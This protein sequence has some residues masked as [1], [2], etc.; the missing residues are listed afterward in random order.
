MHSFYQLIKKCQA[1][2]AAYLAKMT[3][4]RSLFTEL[5]PDKRKAV[6]GAAVEKA[7]CKKALCCKD[8]NK[9]DQSCVEV[10]DEMEV[11][12]SSC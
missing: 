7:E 9:K 1:S 8:G 6:N 12:K 3:A 10:P 2:R 11:R 4:D 5:L